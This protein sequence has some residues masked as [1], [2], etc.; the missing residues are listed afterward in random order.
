MIVH[1]LMLIA[2]NVLIAFGVIGIIGSVVALY[3]KH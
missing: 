3:R 1:E 2:R